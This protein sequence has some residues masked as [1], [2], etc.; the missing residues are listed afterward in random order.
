MQQMMRLSFAPDEDSR[1]RGKYGFTRFEA[2]EARHHRSKD[3]APVEY[4]I[5]AE[6]RNSVTAVAIC[7]T[8]RDATQLWAM[9]GTLLGKIT[10]DPVGAHA[11]QRGFILRTDGKKEPVY[12]AGGSFEP[13]TLYAMLDT[14]TIETIKLADGRL[15]ILDDNGGTNEKLLNPCASALA[16]PVI[17]APVRVVG[18]VVVCPAEY[19]K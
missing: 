19:L 7:L 13:E 1:A 3:G 12:P 10:G 15:M 4:M 17:G 5:E 9:L 2:L 18:D 14:D 11:D 6:Y 16:A 8:E